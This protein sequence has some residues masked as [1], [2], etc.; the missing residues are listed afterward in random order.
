MNEWLF[1]PVDNKFVLY[2]KEKTDLIDWDRPIAA[3]RV[4]P[5]KPNE[6]LNTIMTYQNLYFNEPN[7]A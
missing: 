4:K 2:K 7:V 1:H 5:L 6:I 3:F